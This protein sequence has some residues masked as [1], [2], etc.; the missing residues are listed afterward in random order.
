MK[1][2]KNDVWFADEARAKSPN[3]ILVYSDTGTLVINES[4]ITFE[5]K[6]EKLTVGKN[7]RVSLARPRLNWGSYLILGGILAILDLVLGSG[8]EMPAGE[9]WVLTKL[10]ILLAPLCILAFWLPMQWL[11]VHYKAEGELR[12]A[13]FSLSNFVGFKGMLGGNR[14]LYKSLLNMGLKPHDAA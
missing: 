5:G 1:T 4:D 10:F 11:V 13:Y 12:K 8:V 9:K 3:N 14:A 6:Q 7:A 2:I